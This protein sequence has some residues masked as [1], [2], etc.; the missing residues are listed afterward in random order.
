M[1]RSR[2]PSPITSAVADPVDLWAAAMVLPFEPDP[3]Y[4]LERTAAMHQAAEAEAGRTISLTLAADQLR[5]A[6]AAGTLTRRWVRL[7]PRH[8][9]EYAYQP[10]VTDG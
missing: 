4:P 10:K 1:K 7:R 2:L 9:G 8:R 6:H 5:K 3:L